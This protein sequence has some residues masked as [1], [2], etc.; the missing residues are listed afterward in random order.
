[1]DLDD[2]Q[3]GLLT[4]ADTNRILLNGG[5]ETGQGNE[6][7]EWVAYGPGTLQNVTR[8]LL[9]NNARSGGQ[10]LQMWGAYNGQNN[11][12][13]L[14]QDIPAAPGETWQASIWARNRPGDALQ[15][16]NQMLFKL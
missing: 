9:P 11:S 16:G 12:S 10:C 3:V 8:D 1:M 7:G 15:G 6:F 2:A 5:F 14:Y 4:S 13:G